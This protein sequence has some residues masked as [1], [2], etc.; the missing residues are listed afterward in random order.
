MYLAVSFIFY[1][2]RD[3]KCL[4][5]KNFFLCFQPLMFTAMFCRCLLLTKAWLGFNIFHSHRMRLDFLLV[6]TLNKSIGI[7]VQ[8]FLFRRFTDEALVIFQELYKQKHWTYLAF[9][10][11]LLFFIFDLI[12]FYCKKWLARQR[13]ID[14]EDI[15][16]IPDFEYLALVLLY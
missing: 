14:R 10:S 9:D 16:R 4:N 12:F 7:K 2:L 3:L 13:P 1:D 5:F 6:R 8:L 11:L 15:Q